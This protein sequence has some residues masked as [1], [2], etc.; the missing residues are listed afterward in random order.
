MSANASVI[1]TCLPR[2]AIFRVIANPVKPV[3]GRI[4]QSFNNLETNAG[5]A[6]GI[7]Y[8]SQDRESVPADATC[9]VECLSERT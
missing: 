3:A 5:L 6:V 7:R 2:I 8:Q 1:V 4:L 9:G